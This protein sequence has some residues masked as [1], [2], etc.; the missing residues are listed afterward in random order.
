MPA[1]SQQ[2]S[3]SAPSP[4]VTDGTVSGMH[5]LLHS[6]LLQRFGGNMMFMCLVKAF[7]LQSDP[8]TNEIL[9][10]GQEPGAHGPDAVHNLTSQDHMIFSL[11]PLDNRMTH[12]AELPAKSICKA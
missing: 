1:C 11:L 3:P 7:I 4:H 9:R 2:E 10:Q 6:T 8:I 5:I 12:A